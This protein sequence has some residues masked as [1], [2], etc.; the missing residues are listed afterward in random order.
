MTDDPNVIVLPSRTSYSQANSMQTCS[1]RWALEKGFHVPQRPTW[2]TVGGGAVHQ[3]TEWWDHWTLAGRWETDTAAVAKLFQDAFDKEIAERLEREP[4]YPVDTWRA[5][6]RASKQWPNKEDEGWWRENG[7]SH[8][9]SWVTW[10]TNNPSWEIVNE[11]S[12]GLLGIEVEVKTTFAGSEWIGY[13]DRVFHRN[14]TELLIVDLKSG[15]E[16]D[17]QE[18][19]G[20]YKVGLEDQFGV[21]ATWGAYWMSRTGSTSQFEDMRMWPRE[22]VEYTYKVVRAQQERAEFLPKKSM[23]CSGCSV[24]DYCFAVNGAQSDTIPVPWEV[25]VEIPGPRA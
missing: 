19:L 3:A 1:W 21:T 10:R 23:M 9:M 15:R 5:S 8:V 17:S 14:E 24:R 12:I 11:E 13:I 18:Q 22:R 20:G 16:P 25:S 4:D 7:P 2:A 6:G